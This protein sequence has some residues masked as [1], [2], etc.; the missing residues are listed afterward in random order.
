ME[1]FGLG[2]VPFCNKDIVSQIRR[3]SEAGLPIIVGS[4]CC[5]EGSDLTIYETGQRVLE[6]GGIPT[7]DMTTEAAVTKLMW[8]LGQSKK[9]DDVIRCFQTDLAGEVCLP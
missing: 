5:Y 6:C 1:G 9:R 4:Q 8:A 7:H 2:G 3:S